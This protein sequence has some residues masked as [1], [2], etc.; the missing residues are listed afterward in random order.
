MCTTPGNGI[1]GAESASG[2]SGT[3]GVAW[4]GSDGIAIVAL[5]GCMLR[6]NGAD[7]WR[8]TLRFCVV[9]SCVE[10]RDESGMGVGNAKHAGDMTRLG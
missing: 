9:G 2:V 10:D 4:T 8:A 1:H 6:V 5:G 7:G 3:S